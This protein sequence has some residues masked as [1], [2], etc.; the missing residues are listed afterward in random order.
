MDAKTSGGRIDVRN[1]S[2]DAEV[3]T[4]GGNLTL[5]RVTGKIIG[6]T[7][8]GSIRA[9]IRDAVIGDVRLETSAGN[10]DVSLPVTATV[11][12][13]ASTSMGEIFS[14]LPL[15]TANV[16]RERLRGKLNGGGKSVELK[17]SVG[18]ITIE[19]SSSEIAGR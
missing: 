10:I 3:R 19:P 12:I 17:T 16:G 2:G 6:K 8:G 13:D 4:S 18:N 9:S 7:S 14:R 11:D 1:F 15:E 5:Q